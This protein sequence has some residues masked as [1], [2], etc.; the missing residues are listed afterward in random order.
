M[1]PKKIRK[2]LYA[3]LLIVVSIAYT[4][5][6]ANTSVLAV[7]SEVV[8]TIDVSLNSA[9]SLEE[10]HA[11]KK[12]HKAVTN[13]NAPMF[14]T[15]IQGAD[16][17]LT[18]ADDG[19]TVAKFSL[20]GDADNR[21]ISV[22][23][24]GTISWERLVPTGS[25]SFD[26][27][28]NCTTTDSDC[29]SDWQSVSAASVFDLQA[30]TINAGTGAE[31]RVNVNGGGWF[32]FK[33]TKSTINQDYVKTDYICGKAGRIQITGLNS[34]FEYSIDNGSGFGPWQG[35]IF[36]DLLPGT[37]TVKTRLQ[38]TAGTC[39]YPYE[40]ITIEE[41]TIEID[42]TFVDALCSGDTGSISVSVNNSVPGPYK[43][44]ILDATGTAQEFTAFIA[45]DNYT[46]A[47]VGFGT[48]TVQ[49]ETQQ[50][51]GDPL[52][53]I[54]PPRQNLDTSGNPI[55]IGNGMAALEASTEVNN[56]FGCAN[57]TSVDITVNTTG[58]SAPYTY[59][60][61]GVGPTSTSYTT[62]S[63]YTVTSAGTYDFLITD[64]NG[65]TITASSNVEN[66]SPPV[67]TATGV[68]GTCSNGGARIN[69]N[70]VSA[71]GYNLSYRVNALDPW[72]ANPSISVPAGTYNDIEV[73][74]QQGSFECTMALPLVNVT[75]LGVITGS[76]TK[77]ADRTCD[78][79]G[80]TIG[81]QINFGAASGGFGSGYTFS[82]DG[83][84]FSGSTSFTNLI[85]GTYTPTIEDGGGCR[86]AL[87]PITI[88]D[89]DPP[90]DIDFVATNSNCTAN[91]VD[92]QLVPTSN[93]AIANYSIISPVINNNGTSDTFS[94]LDASLSYIF[95]ITDANGC[96]YTEGYSPAIISSIRA[97]VKSGGDTKICTGATDGSGA[98]L[99]DGFANNYTYNINGG[100]ESAAQNNSEVAITGLG[101]ATYTITITDS[102]TGCI[103][104]ASFTVEEP[105]TA[106]SLTG[107]VTAMTCA[108]GN[109]GRVVASPTGGWGNNRYTLEYPS[110]ATVGPRTGAVFG[111]LSDAG[112]YILSVRDAEGCTDSYTFS[113]TI[114]NAPAISLD[115]TSSDFCFIPGTGATIVVN[116][117][118]G[119]A[120]LGTHQYRINGGALQG[121][122][123]F[124]GLTP[125]NHTIEVV[126]GNN[127]T[128]QISVNIG[129]QL[130]VNTSIDTEIPC[131]GTDG[132]IRVVVSGGYIAD[133]TPKSYEVSADNGANFATAV[134]FTANNFLYGTT[135]PGDYIFRVSD[136]QGCIAQSQPITLNPPQSID[137]ASVTV[138][139]A[140]CGQTDNGIVTITPNATSGV[141]SY[142]ISFNGAAFGT[143][144]TFSNL[145]AGNSYAYVVRDSR[146]CET[147]AASVTIPLDSTP[148]PD[149]TVL[150]TVATCAL[151]ILEGTIEV[152]GV[153]GG[154]ANFTYILQDQFGIEITRTGPT[155]STTT[156]FSNLIPGNY[157]VVTIDALG[158]RDIDT[159]AVIQSA[160][161]VVPDPVTPICNVAGF[162]NT[163]EIFGGTGP[164]LIRLENIGIPT[165]L[166]P[167][168]RRHTFSG[169]EYGITYTV[170]VTDQGTGCVYLE[171]I[172]PVYGPS[173]L[174]VTASTTAGYCDANRFGQITYDITGFAANSNLL[175]ELINDDDGSRITLESPINVS[176]T[177]SGTYEA[178][179]GN[180]QIFVTDLTDNC[181][182][183][184]SVVI[185]QNLPAIDIL[186]M[187]PANC[188]ADGSFTV[189][190]NGGGGGPYTFAF[191]AVGI[192]PSAGDYTPSTTFFGASG[193]YDIYVQDAAGCISFAIAEII[194]LDPAL[195]IPTFA[196]DNQCAVASPSF[197][198]IVR[199]PSSV[200]TPR[201]TLG[202]DSQFPVDNGTFWE[203]T[204][205]VNTPGNYLVDVI[206]A[207]GC[208]SQ[209]TAVVY[210]FLSASGG[211]TTESTCNNADGVITISPNGGSGN[212]DY[213]LTGTDYLSVSVGPITQSS[214]PVFI[215]VVPGVY[216][217][218]ITDR[219]VTDGTNNCTFLVDNINLVGAVVPV[220]LPTTPQNITCNDT[221]ADDGS[222]DIVL[223]AGTDVDAPIDYRLVDFVSRALISNNASGSFPG[224]STGSYEVEVVSARNCTVLSG[225][226]DITE[227]PVFNIDA[228]AT[229]FT[230]ES[231]ANRFSSSIVTATITSPGT[232]TNYRYSITGFENYQTSN[233]FEIIDTGSA[234]NITVY[235][236][237][238]NGCEATASVAINPPM[239]VVSTLSVTRPLNCVQEEIVRIEVSGTTDFTVSTVSV[240]PVAPVTNT[241]GNNY[242]DVL[243]PDSGDYLFEIQ[244]NLPSGCAYPLPI[245]T[246]VVPQAP[247]VIIAETKPIQCFG[248][249]D[250]ELSIEVSD[251][252]GLYSYSVYS[253]TDPGKTTIITSGTNLDT[254]NN[255]ETITGLPGGNFF[256]EVTATAAPFC[257][258][259]SNVA[260]IRTPNGILDVSA[261]EVG[262]VSCTNIT[263][264]INAT[265]V[266]GW[267][268]STYAYRLLKDNGSGYVEEVAFAT[269][270]EF[271]N[272]SSGD[273]RVEVRDFEGC[274][275]TFDITLLQV[276]A[277][278]AGI[279][280]PLAL[281]CPN[282]NNAVLEAFDPTSGDATTAIAG[283]TGGVL[284]AGYS[285][286]LLY[287]N[288][289]SNIDIASTSGL[290]NTP[291]FI[292]ASGGFISGGWYAIEVTSSYDCTFVTEAYF[293]DPPPPIEPRLVQT[294][295]PGCG[296]RGEMRLFVE[297]PEVGFTYEYVGFENG[298]QQGV[299]ADLPASVSLL[300]EGDSGIL[301]QYDIRKK[302]ASN[303][304]LAVRTS[305]VTMT[306]A[307]GITLISNLLDDISCA[308][309]LDGRIE[310][311]V[312]GGVGGEMFT[313]YNGDPVDAFVPVTAAT[314]FRGAQDNGTFEGLPPA[315]DYYIAVTSGATCS[316]IAG[317][318]EI[319]RPAAIQYTPTMQPVTCNGEAN[320][321]IT[322]EVNNGGVGLIQFA[323]APDFN[324]FFSDVSTPGIY[325][326][327]DLEAGSYEV[328]IQDENGC[329]ERALVEVTEPD[330]VVAAIVDIRSETCIGAEDGVV[331][332]S[333]VGGTPFVDPST[334]ATYY[335]TML[336]GPNSD[337]SEVF[338][339]NDALFF[340]NLIGGETYIVI[341]QDANF[342]DA[343]IVIPIE[344]G[345][346]L[347]AEPEVVYGCDGIF[348]NSTASV[349]MMDSSLVPELLFALDPLDPTD[350]VSANASTE[351]VWGDLSAGEHIAYIYHENGC[352]NSVI[353]RTE[354]YEPLTLTA[355][356]TG[357]NEVTA[358]AEGGYGNYEFTFQGE[359]FGTET[360]FTT[361]ESTVVTIEVRDEG[362]CFA[363]VTMPFEF[364]GMLEFPNFFTPDGDGENDTWAPNNRDYF[365]NIEVKIY[366]RYGRVVETLD[367]VDRW[368]GN[369]EATGS[370]L[371]S[372]DYWYVVN[373]NDKSKLQYVGHFTLYR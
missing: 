307:S 304:C 158:C 152:T 61:N 157:T 62:S 347:T 253:A 68:N 55:V 332:I 218:M 292:G 170:E 335:Q 72:D 23:G 373:A 271:Q 312:N 143:Q 252:T 285:Y 368:D 183:A 117:I 43:Y 137:P 180:Y 14:A 269:A 191:M 6:I 206:D 243:L 166:T 24:S 371:P 310:S 278:D 7:L 54:D 358:F 142:E 71:N 295:V 356:K 240:L 67:V 270:N 101:P 99:I 11:S 120:I 189:Q 245:H 328:L 91:T 22:S 372:G 351:Y 129:T 319:N 365:L 234:Q 132:Q 291:T 162:T 296:G 80:G 226:L 344:I 188:T 100:T 239:D 66:L 102:D 136:N 196:V 353:F 29:S 230:C 233:I 220:I 51:T 148:A 364:T 223:Q 215:G 49:V 211:F 202:G 41:K 169:L 172:P 283:A 42:V 299:Y 280:E 352:T 15:I 150:P 327:E 26:I 222:I 89:V 284:G 277:I 73:R 217:V 13:S 187:N 119:S 251:Y 3:L 33:V 311:F 348:P 339:R 12:T 195:P 4:S 254:A 20:C 77:I 59:I 182:D 128:D 229:A 334:F 331:S 369:Y 261:V 281:Q 259:D 79:A 346:D 321:A 227:P 190:G 265:A 113:L 212:F 184:T 216:Q 21:L 308:S 82:I 237:D 108:N 333:V 52:N 300:I 282:G 362:G 103:D 357:P 63:T 317:P 155:T 324:Q 65:C 31:F 153:A 95:Q 9:S 309:E 207:N 306:D 287:L 165:A 123:I 36:G 260:T 85:A 268:T 199:V 122:T 16:S 315:T 106:L 139:P 209:G 96:T 145:I 111:N 297:N 181:T 244:D 256:V 1:L 93:A 112:T 274:T 168:P 50:C 345:V 293:V 367:Q 124:T 19:S 174:G 163:V 134:A 204:Y 47:A 228:T 197:D 341:I 53:G 92:L 349:N 69:F 370:P 104:T 264:V 255:P 175:V 320:G 329:F 314:V 45:A 342:C 10:K 177:H 355:E 258:G 241:S 98:F 34:G 176:P 203:Y 178:L 57:I 236:I 130:R 140:S 84:N 114:L 338:L 350:A 301:Y 273:Y 116:S 149:A 192:T 267:D 35:P 146:G 275:D 38:N 313:L 48:Y 262:N 288:S 343:D 298:I 213:V 39:E 171:E 109:I 44:T 359:S 318:F 115:A 56:S 173:T 27:N 224:L 316:Y 323:L 198:I 279:R 105:T 17:E 249:S 2:V 32:Y 40:P 366:D 231:G 185:V 200:D 235:A 141:P 208:T 8:S 37:Y 219:D 90:S 76:A 330:T 242:V 238:D 25:C 81:G 135:V 159:V 246:V 201:F 138:I 125:G 205:S 74:Y 164:F 322:I 194:P 232:P 360:V 161:T 64:D 133:A 336:I 363:L 5:A 60:V 272:L 290:Q 303:T 326:F 302:N 28:E 151:G 294:K 46:F 88:D 58:G 86:L 337:G 156:T 127:C 83:L 126:D 186:S 276:P 121:S 248:G 263:G 18:C 257:L 179:P 30:S 266:G 144:S 131:G 340:E 75:T 118:A 250:G 97:R 167:G 70:V 305:G 289:N 110:G 247:T 154:T 210:E 107:S 225:R 160:L 286:R 214:N 361:N 87:T 147:L 221:N 94:S 354:V 78:G 325:T 193:N